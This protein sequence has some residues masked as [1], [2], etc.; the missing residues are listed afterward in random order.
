MKESL[1]MRTSA[2]E[3]AARIWPMATP[4]VAACLVTL[5]VLGATIDVVSAEK[6]PG[7]YQNAFT[8][9]CRERGGTPKRV[10]SRVVK[11]TLT[12]G[13][14][15][16]CDFNFNPPSCTKELMPPSGAGA[17]AGGGAAVDPSGPAEQP[18]SSKPVG[19]G[20]AVDPSGSAEQPGVSA[21]P[22]LK[23]DDHK[24]A[25]AAHNERSNA[26]HN[27]K[28]HRDGHGKSRARKR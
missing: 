14:V 9:T 17:N 28:R 18:D 22:I 8:R 6:S 15:I 26:K 16:T 24:I 1:V 25:A 3:G 7:S 5:L 19:G 20:A 10:R 2:A 21:G 27:G 4:L 11:C 23:A 12:D 13:T